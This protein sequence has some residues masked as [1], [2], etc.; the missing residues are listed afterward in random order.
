MLYISKLIASFQN[1]NTQNKILVLMFCG[2]AAF[3]THKLWPAKAA[4][5]CTKPHCVKLEK[6][7]S[8][9]I[10]FSGIDNYQERFPERVKRFRELKKAE[11]EL[12]Q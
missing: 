1:T 12:S 8:E 11:Q 7:P 3:M 10:W 2:F 5:E 4:T 6:L 9:E